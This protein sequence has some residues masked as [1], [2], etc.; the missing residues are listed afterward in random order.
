MCG[1]Q[2][3]DSEDRGR[4]SEVARSEQIGLIVIS[5]A[6]AHTTNARRTNKETAALPWSR[7]VFLPRRWCFACFK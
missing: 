3:G 1:P 5:S 7:P 4:L 2:V 6:D